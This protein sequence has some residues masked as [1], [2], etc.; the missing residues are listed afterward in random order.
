M[1]QS[2]QHALARYVA[3][4]AAEDGL[5][6][7]RGRD[8]AAG[9]RVRVQS[10]APFDAYPFSLG[11]ASGDPL[12]DGIVLWT[13]LA[14]DAARGRRHADGAGRGRLGDRRGRAV[15][16]DRA[17]GRRRWRDPSS[18]T[19]CTSTSRGWSPAASTGTAS[20]RA[21][22]SAR[23]GARRPRRPRAPPVDRLRFG[24]CGCSHYETGYFT[25][26]AASPK[27]SSTSCSTP[28]TTSTRAARTAAAP[29]P[30]AAAQRR[31]DL[32]A[33]RLPQPLRAL[34]VRSAT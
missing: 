11:V 16:D 21:T 23:S 15:P 34:Q 9:R 2:T 25:P 5:D 6:A 31:R 19:A 33:G 28:A 17:E 13:R 30:R 8:R 4:R 26:T 29:R 3:P 22:R 32:H 20:A 18:G 12:P 14:P 24:V 27:S 1:S 10:A 7:R